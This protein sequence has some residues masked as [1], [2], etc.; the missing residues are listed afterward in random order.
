[1]A[2]QLVSGATLADKPLLLVHNRLGQQWWSVGGIGAEFADWL[3]RFAATRFF[4]CSDVG[5]G[6]PCA[7]HVTLIWM[8]SSWVSS[9]RLHRAAERFR[10]LSKRMGMP[11]LIIQ[12]LYLILVCRGLRQR[13]DLEALAVGHGLGNVFV[14]LAGWAGAQQR[15]AERHQVD[16]I[17]IG[18]ECLVFSTGRSR[19]LDDLIDLDV[20]LAEHFLR[21]RSVLGPTCLDH[22]LD[23][24][25]LVPS[26]PMLQEP[27]A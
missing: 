3:Q 27:F 12:T 24:A 18:R 16:R 9:M 5:A 1:M 13:I 6:R 7:S 26:K 8:R 17:R 21:I 15:E 10:G 11:M 25:A 23:P 2:S 19:P 22:G 4:I 20:C 14:A